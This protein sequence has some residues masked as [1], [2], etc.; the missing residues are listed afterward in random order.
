[1]SYVEYFVTYREE[2]RGK[3][4]E[5]SIWGEIWI[6]DLARYCTSTNATITATVVAIGTCTNIEEERT[7]CCVRCIIYFP[8]FW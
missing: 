6:Q 1:M 4:L 5:F 3:S 8:R 7:V 2:F